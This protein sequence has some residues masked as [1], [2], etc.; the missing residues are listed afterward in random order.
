MREKKTNNN[1]H[2]NMAFKSLIV[3]LFFMKVWFFLLFHAI[4]YWRITK[5]KRETNN[6]NKNKNKNKSKQ[7]S[8]HVNF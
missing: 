1:V 4:T 8:R 7:K 6:K 3:S 2:D 5:I